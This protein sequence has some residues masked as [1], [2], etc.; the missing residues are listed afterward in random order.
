MPPSCRDI[1]APPRNFVGL[2]LAILRPF[3]ALSI[4]G[5]CL[6][7][8]G[9]EQKNVENLRPNPW[10]QRA[11]TKT[12]YDERLAPQHGFEARPDEASCCCEEKWGLEVADVLIRHGTRT[13]DGKKLRKWEKLRKEKWSEIV[14]GKSSSVTGGTKNGKGTGGAVDDGSYTSERPFTSLYANTSAAVLVPRGWHEL[15]GLGQRWRKRLRCD[16][17][18]NA[19]VLQVWETSFKVRSIASGRAFEA[20]FFQDSKKMDEVLTLQDG[21]EEGDDEGSDKIK[22]MRRVKK[23]D[24]EGGEGK[25]EAKKKKDSQMKTATADSKELLAKK[26]KLL[27]SRL[28]VNDARLRFFDLH[29]ASRKDDEGKDLTALDGYR[30]SQKFKSKELW[31]LWNYAIMEHAVMG[32]S[33]LGDALLGDGCGTK[34][35]TPSLC[36]RLELVADM[37]QFTKNGMGAGATLHGFAPSMLGEWTRLLSQVAENE[38]DEGGT[39]PFVRFGFGHAETVL[40][41]M[42]WLGVYR[43]T[44]PKIEDYFLAQPPTPTVGTVEKTS[45]SCGCPS[46]T[47][48]KDEV[49]TSALAPFA[50]NVGFLIWKSS[51]D[52]SADTSEKTSPDFCV[53]LIVNEDVAM[54]WSS[55]D[56]A[57]RYLEERSQLFAH[58]A[59]QLPVNATI[60]QEEL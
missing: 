5:K 27:G 52:S 43:G 3:A 57:N 29:K 49:R 13:P 14:G 8:N 53:Q 40:P 23:G 35:A 6:S 31:Q 55:L 28:R 50:A 4:S 48:L 2:R 41:L 59:S 1:P 51:G 33:T 47:R 7:V 16:Q 15:R 54:Q 37:A 20:G 19:S 42:A 46:F 36:D 11:G 34:E 58:Y 32:G 9:E 26:N 22:A 25:K 30:T 24:D 39:G 17:S 18:T 56:E 45:E 12:A 60:T 10:S 44:P 21:A 38:E